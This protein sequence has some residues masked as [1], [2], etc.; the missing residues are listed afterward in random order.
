[1]IEELNSI[2]ERE[3]GGEKKERGGEDRSRENR[4]P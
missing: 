2:C 3:E 4:T 1:M